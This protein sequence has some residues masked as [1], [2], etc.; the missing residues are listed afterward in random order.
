M[1][2]DLNVYVPAL[3]RELLPKLKRRLIDFG[4]ECEFH[5][6]FAFDQE[7]DSGFLPI[8][9]RVSSS[10]AQHYPDFEI[11]T[12]IEI[13]I[14]D[15]DYGEELAQMAS[16]AGDEHHHS[17]G[18]QQGALAPCPYVVSKEIDEVLKGCRKLAA[19][20]IQSSPVCGFRTGLYFAAILAEL[21]S[22]IIFDPQKGR[23]VTAGDAIACFPAE[24][25]DYENSLSPREWDLVTFEGWLE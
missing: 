22:G 6:D 11:L 12:G 20:V 1:S 8:K 7:T 23:F 9:M 10:D 2:T 18:L 19:I 24:V 14:D 25:V 3:D 17:G 13:F 4:M 21:T 5:P 15:Y 16:S